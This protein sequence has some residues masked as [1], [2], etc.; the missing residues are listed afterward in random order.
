MSTSFI[1][2][3]TH[4]Q[5][6]GHRDPEIHTYLGSC[7]LV[8]SQRDDALDPGGAD[9][10]YLTLDHQLN[11]QQDDHS[12]ADHKL[13]KRIRKAVTF[14]TVPEH[15]HSLPNRI[16]FDLYATISEISKRY[17]FRDDGKDR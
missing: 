10:I 4:T 6:E 2:Q 5:R 13:E 3:H 15:K 8:R 14:K 1:L 16:T 11:G 17:G 12:V 7:H 9:L